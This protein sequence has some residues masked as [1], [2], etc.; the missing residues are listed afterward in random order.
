MVSR[1][2]IPRYGRQLYD[3]LPSEMS[4]DSETNN[5]MG[6]NKKER[7]TQMKQELN[8]LTRPILSRSCPAGIYTAEVV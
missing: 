3:F 2:F 6:N 4:Q 8:S 5:D 7:H 1:D